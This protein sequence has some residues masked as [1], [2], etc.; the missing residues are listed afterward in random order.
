MVTVREFLE[1]IIAEQGT[2]SHLWLAQNARDLLA[3][4]ARNQQE[5]AA[6]KAELPVDATDRLHSAD[7]RRQ[8]T[9]RHC[10]AEALQRGFDLG[11]ASLSD[12]QPHD[13]SAGDPDRMLADSVRD[14]DDADR[15]LATAQQSI[16]RLREAL[17]ELI[18]TNRAKA[19]GYTVGAGGKF[20]GHGYVYNSFADDLEAALT[21]IQEPAK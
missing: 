14:A 5:I 18:A 2:N 11:R 4:Y 10:E 17:K 7:C 12:A 20:A 16:A 21:A 9:D 6:L 3:Q 15:R 19:H 8:E 1:T 13:R